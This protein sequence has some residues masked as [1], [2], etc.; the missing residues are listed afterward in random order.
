MFYVLLRRGCWR[1]KVYCFCRNMA[2]L[3]TAVASSD[4]T[5]QDDNGY[6]LKGGLDKGNVLEN[7][8]VK[9]EQMRKAEFIREA[10]KLKKQIALLEK[11]KSVNLFSKNSYFR[12]EY[13]ALEELELKMTNNRNAE[14]TNIEQQLAKVH[15][16][17]KRLQ[18]QL[19]D[20]KPT[21]EF[22]EKLREMMEETEKAI[23]AFKEEQRRVYESL[24]KEEKIT[25]NELTAL[26]KKM[27]A[28]TLVNASAKKTPTSQSTKV[29]LFKTVHANLPVEVVE[30]EKYLEDTGGR[31]GGWDNYDHQNFLKVW[32]KYKG[33]AQFLEEALQY[34]PGRTEDDVKQHEQWY[35]EFLFLEERKKEA[36]QK[37]KSKK[38][39][40]KEDI[41]KKKEKTE[42]EFE[43]D[44]L[45]YEEAEKKRL[46]MEK[47]E[48][49]AQLEEWKKKKEIEATRLKEKR[50]EEE[51]ERERLQKEERKRQLEVKLAVEE[52]I[53][54]KKEQEALQRLEK[55]VIEQTEKE[56]RRKAASEEIS[57]FQERDM[58]VLESKLLEKRAKEAE[59][60]EREKKLAKLK[61]KVDSHVR[62][63]PSRLW[64]PTKGWEERLKVQGPEGGGPLL[65]IPQ[66]AVPS[67]RQGL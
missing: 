16:S 51:L 43:A 25:S 50:L 38:Q 62:R 19:M 41:L 17:V 9:A 31:Q 26:D 56:E 29:P 4:T 67:W 40:I 21:P 11:D 22:V 12:M 42:E 49:Q 47:R 66:R 48:K 54:Q 33:K 23:S 15:N 30:L 64:K 45:A 5:W 35:Q 60:K 8:R 57:R 7:W 27:E 55:E 24:L 14:R 44:R 36:I 61:E 2:T 34:L 37:W 6:C 32:T 1:N 10:D 46:E 20:A 59:E 28:W 3:T 58:Q 65:Y 63:D 18:R 52:Y 13:S 39:Q 53:R